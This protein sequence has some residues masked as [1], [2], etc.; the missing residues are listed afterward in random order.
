MKVDNVNKSKAIK[1]ISQE[2]PWQ[3]SGS[4]SAL[5]VQ[6]TQVQSLVGILQVAQRG[7]KKP[8]CLKYNKNL[9]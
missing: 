4:D 1:I 3:S 9:F 6:G 2:I 8:K 7:Q 5:P